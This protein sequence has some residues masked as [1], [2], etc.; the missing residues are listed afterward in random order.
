MTFSGGVLITN[1]AGTG[2]SGGI[3]G[4][5]VPTAAFEFA[6]QFGT[7]SVAGDTFTFSAIMPA[8][9]MVN[10][11]GQFEISTGSVTITLA[12]SS[13]DVTVG[14][15]TGTFTLTSPLETLSGTIT[16]TYTAESL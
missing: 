10:A 1:L 4:S 5:L 2:Y 6:A 3:T 13:G 8:G 11:S 7:V 16:G 9:F 15:A 12:P 14:N